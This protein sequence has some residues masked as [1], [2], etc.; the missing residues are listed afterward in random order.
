[1]VK[2]RIFCCC[3]PV[4]AGVV[5]STDFFRKRVPIKHLQILSML[6]LLGGAGIAAIGIVNLRRNCTFA[7]IPS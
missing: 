5:V 7:S 4:R 3:I 6:G 1:M 2:S